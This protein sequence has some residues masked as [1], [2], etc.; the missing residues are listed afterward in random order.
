[1]NVTEIGQAILIAV[2]VAIVTKIIGSVIDKSI[3]SGRLEAAARK[4][5][6]VTVSTIQWFI[7][8]GAIGFAILATGLF[9]RPIMTRIDIPDANGPL[10]AGAPVG[11]G[12]ESYNL[13]TGSTYSSTGLLILAGFALAGGAFGAYT[14]TRKSPPPTPE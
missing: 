12:S 14:G 7:I 1:M 3:E 13:E 4:S 8:G 5:A 6:H 10:T 9:S 2:L 11:S